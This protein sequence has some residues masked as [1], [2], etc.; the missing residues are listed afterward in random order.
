M[1]DDF[2]TL[3]VCRN[4]SPRCETLH[5]PKGLQSYVRNAVLNVIGIVCIAMLAGR[6][7]LINNGDVKD[8]RLHQLECEVAMLREGLRINGA[9]GCQRITPHR[10]P[11]YTN[12]ERMAILELRAMRA[13]PKWKRPPFLPDGRH[14][15]SVAAACRRRCAGSDQ[16]AHESISGCVA[17]P[18][19]TSS[20]SARRWARRRSPKRRPGQAF[21]SARRPFGRILK[22]KPVDAPEMPTK[23]AGTQCRVVSKYW[24]APGMWI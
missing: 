9:P 5:L 1:V 12:V 15:P 17:T 20:C 6:E 18:F 23:D 7:A 3:H 11:Q 19:N 2:R 4:L 13:G 16:D 21:T 10:R 24:A 22:E 14:R 8:A